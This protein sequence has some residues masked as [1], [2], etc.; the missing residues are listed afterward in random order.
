DARPAEADLPQ[1]GRIRPLRPL[2][3]QL[4]EDRQGRGPEGADLTRPMRGHAGEAIAGIGLASFV[5]G[6]VRGAFAGESLRRTSALPDA[7]DTIADSLAKSFRA[8]TRDR[9][10]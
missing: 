8:A 5:N 9:R 1:D 7:A 3:V 2:G 6:T 4:G 10:A